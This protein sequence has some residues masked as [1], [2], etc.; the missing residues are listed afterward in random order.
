MMEVQG[1]WELAKSLAQPTRN[2]MQ[3]DVA[4]QSAANLRAQG[5]TVTISTNASGAPVI[6]ATPGG[7]A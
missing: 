3:W 7:A 2:S 5:Y 1:N 4:E 6:H